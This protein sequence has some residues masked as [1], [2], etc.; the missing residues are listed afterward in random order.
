MKNIS[1]II[2][3]GQGFL[4]NNVNRRNNQGPLNKEEV[5]IPVMM[6]L[7]IFARETRL[8]KKYTINF[9]D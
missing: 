3:I 7:L 9:K 4:Q 6:M 1:Y 8:I 2:S 5:K